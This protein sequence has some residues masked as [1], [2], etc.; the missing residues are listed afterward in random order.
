MKKLTKIVVFLLLLLALLYI[1]NPSEDSLVRQGVRTHLKKS[2]KSDN[3]FSS[4]MKAG[5]MN[6]IKMSSRCESHFFYSLGSYKV[7]ND[8][9]KSFGMLWIWVVYSCE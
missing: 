1:S 8:E 3:L 4:L 2:N 5:L 9:C 7:G 6:Q